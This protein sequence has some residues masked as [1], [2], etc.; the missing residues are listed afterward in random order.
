MAR[1]R[2]QPRRDVRD[3]YDDDEYYD[4]YDE[5]SRIPKLRLLVAAVVLAVLAAGGGAFLGL[6]GGTKASW[7][8]QPEAAAVA[9]VLGGLSNNAKQPTP[10]VLAG[11][12]QPLLGDA[13]LGPRVMASVVDVNSGQA[14]FD[15]GGAQPVVPASTAKLVTAAA[16]L[17]T[18]G[19]AYQ[20]PTRAVVG[21]SSGEVVLIGGG[22]PTL[23][24]NANG[25][26]PGAARLDLLAAQVLKA[27][28][29]QKATKVTVDAS[30]YTGPAFNPSWEEIDRGQYITNMSAL[31]TD[32]GLKDPKRPTAKDAYSLQP[33]ISAGQVFATML[34]VSAPVTLGNAPP[35]AD[36]LGQVLSLPVSRMVETM[37][38]KSDNIIA[39]AMSRQVALARNKPASFEG[40]ADATREVLAD[41]KLPVD[42]FGMVDGSGLSYS[43]HVTAQ[44]LTSVLAMAASPQHG[45][46][47]AI[48][49]GLP[50]AGWSGTLND[51][52][53]GAGT[54]SAAGSVRAKTGTLH[55]VDSLAGLV[56]D[57]DGRLLAF[58]VVADA[59]PSENPA[60][61]ALDKIAATVAACGCA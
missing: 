40:G 34:G 7:V 46:L 22:D 39:E 49:S 35:K 10:A 21:A 9:P 29:G 45:E 60:E 41:L 32:G 38:T 27:L 14:L 4:D 61:A 55:G 48:I 15:A 23:A 57:A 8:A 58:S 18:R 54:S 43:D 37:L 24:V 2:P 52:Y 36:Q 56:V 53:T 30:L 42:G 3:D 51:R 31:M 50:V 20:I 16:V 17:R 59:T 33:E 44:L 6:R 28:G 47:R 12:L 19:P 1:P 11:L 25:S 5:P 26:Y 13:R